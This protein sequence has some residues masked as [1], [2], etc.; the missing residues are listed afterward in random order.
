[1]S[2]P[3]TPKEIECIGFKLTDLSVD[4]N[5][6]YLE[7]GCGYKVVTEPSDPATCEKF[8]NVMRNGPSEMVNLAN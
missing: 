5:K 3:Y 8:M 7:F 4:F 6:G 1:L 2:N